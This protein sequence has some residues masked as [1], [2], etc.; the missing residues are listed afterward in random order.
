MRRRIE[1][2]NAE[3][4]EAQGEQGRADEARLELEFTRRLAEIEAQI[5]EARDFGL[6]DRVLLLEQEKQRL[7]ELLRLRREALKEEQRAREERETE[8]PKAFEKDTESALHYASALNRVGELEN[9]LSR[10]RISNLERESQAFGAAGAGL[11]DSLARSGFS[12]NDIRAI[13]DGLRRLWDL[14]R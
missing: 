4:A 1:L 12:E 5:Q 11:R 10:D 6:R 2:L 14:R 13:D 9:Q 8:R 7:L 3:I